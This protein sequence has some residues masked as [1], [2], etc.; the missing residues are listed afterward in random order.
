VLLLYNEADGIDEDR[1][2]MKIYKDGATTSV[3]V[4]RT[5]IS[6]GR[7]QLRYK[8]FCFKAYAAEELPDAKKAKG[9]RQRCITFK[10]TYGSPRYDIAEVIEPGRDKKTPRILK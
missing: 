1:T 8:T 9:F 4:F 5:D 10:C 7:K 6:F 3:H 2:K